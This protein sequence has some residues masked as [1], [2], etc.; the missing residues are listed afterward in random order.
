MNVYIRSFIYIH[1]FVASNRIAPKKMH[2]TII[3]AVLYEIFGVN[4]DYYYILYPM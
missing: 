1:G 4:Y 3:V 2:W